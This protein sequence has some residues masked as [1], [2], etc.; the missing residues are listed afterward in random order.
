MRILKIAGVP[1]KIK[2][3]KEDAV[4]PDDGDKCCAYVSD[5]TGEAGFIKGRPKEILLADMIHECIHALH[6]NWSENRVCKLER[7]LARFLIENGLVNWKRLQQTE[8]KR[9]L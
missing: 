7:E 3:H 9:K 4:C 2:W 5:K 8:R 1:Y 6:R